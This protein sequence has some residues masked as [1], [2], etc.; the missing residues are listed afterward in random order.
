[1]LRGGCAQSKLG[2]IHPE[3]PGITARGAV[4]SSYAGAGKKTELHQTVSNFSWDLEPFEDSIF[5]LS[6]VEDGK[7]GG[8]VP[9]LSLLETQLHNNFRIGQETGAVKDPPAAYRDAC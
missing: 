2:T 6:Q 7:L 1:M 3:H 5:A 4:G 9:P 8:A